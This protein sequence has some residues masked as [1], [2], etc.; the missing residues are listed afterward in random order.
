MMEIV[1][2]NI[3]ANQLPERRLTG[4]LIKCAKANTVSCKMLK[5]LSGYPQPRQNLHKIAILQ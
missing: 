3:I 5:L 1:A 4:I 2:T